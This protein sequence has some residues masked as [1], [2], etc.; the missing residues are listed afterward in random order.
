MAWSARDFIE[1]KEIGEEAFKCRKFVE[2]KR[3]RIVKRIA[4]IYGAA[5]ER[6][7]S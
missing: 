7:T 2:R 1:V 3:Y 6:V 5:I 4:P